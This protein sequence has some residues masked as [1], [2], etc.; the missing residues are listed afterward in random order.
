MT[1][2]HILSTISARLERDTFIFSTTAPTRLVLGLNQRLTPVSSATL[3]RWIRL[4]TPTIKPFTL[5][6]VT[7]HQFGIMSY[8]IELN[9]EDIPAD[10]TEALPIGNYAWYWSDS[11][12][13]YPE[14]TAFTRLAPFPEMKA[15][16]DPDTLF[17]VLPLVA[18]AVRQR[19]HHQC[20]VT[21]IVSPDDVGLVWVFPPYFIYLLFSYGDPFSSD[22][23]F[24]KTASNAGFM[25]KRLMPFYLGN[26]FSI[27]VDDG[28]RVVVFRDMG[29]AQLLLP[30]HI[31]TR[32]GQGPDDKF[33]REHFRVSLQVNLLGGDICE[34][35][36]HNDILS[37][38][39]ELG[40]EGEDYVEP[41]PLTDPRWQT[42]LGKAI[43][44]DVLL[45]KTTVACLDDLDPD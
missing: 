3:H 2:S 16:N 8:A 12:R 40:V 5:H 15:H 17:D 4:I 31:F 10:S 23:E 39:E 42:V 9:G 26:A 14:I 11:E 45:S 38:M 18:E 41:L 20:F 29:S 25:H 19:D 32:D 33:L 7:V 21:G 34:D 44:E 35:Y 30:S 22:P 36:D 24:F 37:M 1:S 43:F 6:P 28:H 13:A 27:D